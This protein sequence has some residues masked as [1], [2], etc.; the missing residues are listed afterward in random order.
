MSKYFQKVA[1]PEQQGQQTAAPSGPTKDV[2]AHAEAEQGTNLGSAIMDLIGGTAK[3]GSA[4]KT[5]DAAELARMKAE[6]QLDADTDLADLGS[7]MNAFIDEK[8]EGKGIS[9]YEPEEL[10]TAMDEA[11]SSF[12]KSKNLGDKDYFEL[13]QADIKEKSGMFFSKQT[14]ANQ[15][16]QQEKRYGSLMNSVK[17]LFSA[18]NDPKE[19]IAELET[20]IEESVGLEP[21]TILV[22]GKEVI[23]N[24]SIR[25]T[26]ENAKLRMVQPILE[27]IMEKR[28]PNALKL[29]ESQEFKDFFDFPDY[30]NV[31]G[32][33]KQQVQSTINKKRQLS[34]DSIEEQ[35][36]FGI[37]SGMF[38]SSKDIKSFFKEKVDTMS[39]E[40]RP[41]TRQLMKLESSMLK[42]V[43]TEDSFT[44]LYPLIKSGDYT[45]LDRSGLK[46]KEVETMK[47]KFFT[48][49]TGID[50]LSPQG[51]SDAIKSGTY[52]TQLKSYFESGY[53]LPP[54]L[55][56][57][58]NTPPSG[59]IRGVREKYETFI[60]LNTLTQDT[61]TTTLDLFKPKEYGRM[62]FAGNLI[63]NIDSGVMDDKEAQQVYATFNNDL[64]KN[65]DSFG[66]YVSPKAEAALSSEDVT[67]WLA[68]QTT[69]APWTYDDFSSQAYMGRQFKNYFSYAM[70]TTDDP[71]QAQELAEKMFYSRHTAFENPD[72]SEGV[73]THEFKQ[74]DVNDFVELAENLP[75][76]REIKAV[77]GYLGFAKDFDFKGNLA[78]RPDP[79]YEKTKLM[80]MY[81]DDKFITSTSA[82][83]MRSN[84]NKINAKKIRTAEERN[85]QTTQN[86]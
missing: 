64:N 31:I 76:F 49:E 69:D 63:D 85:V 39:K 24:P 77:A 84:L 20:K 52:D 33:A 82:D 79:S 34:F 13:L 35:G 32:S 9:D 50:D 57:W 17:G 68:D 28:D 55:E 12:I 40:D 46:K 36:F 43:E 83:L 38:K 65:T 67:K 30:D 59:G 18:S 2:N 71:E 21:K 16:K 37:D 60:Q 4:I 61:S 22:D 19:I 8:E 80:H 10:R 54:H 66:T 48:V 6:N 75:E 74:F 7:Y 86:K 47:N 15:K 29:L 26:A 58:A 5:Y 23:V 25:D 56:S 51:I 62:M 27:S 70:E 41:D 14:V 42:A 81:Y 53:A 72:G 3:I 73:L 44:Q 78:F 45:A 11:T 1:T